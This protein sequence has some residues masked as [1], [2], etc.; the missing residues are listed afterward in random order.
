ML[1]LKFLVKVSVSFD[2]KKPSI[3]FRE[4]LSSVG[5]DEENFVKKA[6]EDYKRNNP[7]IKEVAIQILQIERIP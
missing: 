5:F 6:K 7:G 2:E 3:E 1:P 4:Y